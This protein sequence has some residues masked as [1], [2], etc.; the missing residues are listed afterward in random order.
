MSGIFGLICLDGKPV[1]SEYVQAMTKAMAS[2]GPNGVVNVIRK[3]AMLGY[4]HLSATPEARYER[5]PWEDTRISGIPHHRRRPARQSGGTLRPFPH[6]HA[7]AAHRRRRPPRRPGLCSAGARMPRP[8]CS[9]TG[10]SPFGTKS[11]VVCSSPAITWAT[12]AFFTAAILRS[13]LLR[14]PR[15]PSLPCPGFPGSW[16]NGGWPAIWPSFRAMRPNG[17]ARTGRTSDPFFRPIAW[18][19]IPSLAAPGNSGAWMKRRPFDWPPKKIIWKDSSTIFA[20]PCGCTSVPSV[21]SGP[22]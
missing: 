12:R 15:G 4:T 11:A 13:S 8:A 10:P 1:P 6:P 5:M 7:R 3:S 19:S 9:A 17:P 21:P 16:M 2:W 20:G 14:R 18:P 22:N